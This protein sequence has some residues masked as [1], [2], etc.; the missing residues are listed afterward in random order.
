M[1]IQFNN[2][3]TKLGLDDVLDFGAWIGHTVEEVIRQKPE[4]I[5]WLM[6]N[7]DKKFYGSVTDEIMRTKKFKAVDK[8]SRGGYFY[9]GGLRGDQAHFEAEMH[10]SSWGFDDWMDDIPF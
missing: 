9:D 10:S 2:V 3:R 1:A 6:T 7:T 4:Y 8:K 5:S